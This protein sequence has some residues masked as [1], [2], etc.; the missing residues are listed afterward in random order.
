MWWTKDRN[1]EQ[2]FVYEANSFNVLPILP[3]VGTYMY[4]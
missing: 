3:T 4:K 1:S 2:I